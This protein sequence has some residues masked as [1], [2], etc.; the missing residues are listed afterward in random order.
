MAI[1]WRSNHEYG[2][3]L[4]AN[5]PA[6]DEARFQTT[7]DDPIQINQALHY[8]ERTVASG[9]FYGKRRDVPWI[10]GQTLDLNFGPHNAAFSRS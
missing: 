5:R 6:E 3:R 10:P 7:G 9:Q 2:F 1:R 4:I 8:T